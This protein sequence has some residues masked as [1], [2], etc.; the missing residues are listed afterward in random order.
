MCLTAND[1][2]PSERTPE[3]HRTR[4]RPFC[5]VTRVLIRSLVAESFQHMRHC[6]LGHC[7]RAI[8]SLVWDL[9]AGVASTQS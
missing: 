8:A 9:S 1:R 4:S 5:T 7:C 6:T 3:R 2:E